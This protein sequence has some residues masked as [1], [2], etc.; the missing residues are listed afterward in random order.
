MKDYTANI[1]DYRGGK[2]LL[3]DSFDIVQMVSTKDANSAV[4]EIEEKCNDVDYVLLITSTPFHM[5]RPRIRDIFKYSESKSS[6]N[7]YRHITTKGRETWRNYLEQQ[8]D[9]LRTKMFCAEEEPQ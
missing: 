7:C 5:L 6:V 4:K 3:I 1:I 2:A 9:E 8:R